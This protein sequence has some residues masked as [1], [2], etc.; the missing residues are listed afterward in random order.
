LLSCR[1]KISIVRILPF[2]W[3]LSMKKKL[4]IF[5]A[6]AAAMVLSSGC[7]GANKESWIKCPKCNTYFRTQEGADWFSN[8]G[9]MGH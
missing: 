4:G 7:A 3:R 1:I 5:L 8:M 6:L 2:D 9:N